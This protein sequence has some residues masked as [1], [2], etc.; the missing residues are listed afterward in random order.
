MFLGEYE[1]SMDERGRVAVPAR[2]RDEFKAG[3]VLARGLDRC[4]TAYS[5]EGWQRLTGRLESLSFTQA[6]VRRVQRAV[7][8]GAYEAELD[9]QGRV[10]LPA[11]LRSYA[12]IRQG[13]VIVGMNDHLEL[14]DAEHW[15][16]EYAALDSQ[17]PEIAERLHG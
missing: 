8:G 3:L 6:D 15:A 11:A 5:P 10:L 9:R 7:Y 13:V 17:T 4:I 16:A 2:F 12:E 1:Y 14:W